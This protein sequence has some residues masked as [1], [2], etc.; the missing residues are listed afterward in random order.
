MVIEKKVP[1]N[2]VV[3]K[4]YLM[5][6]EIYFSLVEIFYSSILKWHNALETIIVDKKVYI[7][8]HVHKHNI[9]SQNN[10]LLNIYLIGKTTE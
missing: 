5:K 3:N 4:I 1:T 8:K 6:L 9:I 7:L 2:S 10:L